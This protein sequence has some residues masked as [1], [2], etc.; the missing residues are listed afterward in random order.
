[1]TA[2]PAPVT[3]PTLD[4]VPR[5]LMVAM[6]YGDGWTWDALQDIPDQQFHSYQ[7]VEGQVVI[8]PSPNRLHQRAVGRIFIALTSSAPRE[9]EVFVAPFDFVP[10][11]VG[12]TSLQP[13]VLVALRDEVEDKRLVV[14]PVLAVEVLSPSRRTFDTTTKR[15][16]YARFGVRHHWVIDPDEPSILALELRPD[17]EYTEVAAARGDETFRAAAPFAVEIVPS[18]LVVD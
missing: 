16:L 13:D 3:T 12:T 17:G 15:A 18:Q 11:G 5:E 4:D 2:E 8:S 1:M 9:F 7:L 14:P 6:P 10:G